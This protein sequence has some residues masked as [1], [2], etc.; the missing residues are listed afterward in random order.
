MGPAHNPKQM[1]LCFCCRA[2]HAAVRC[3]VLED[4]VSQIISDTTNQTA[5]LGITS[6]LWNNM[7]SKQFE[8]L[9]PRDVHWKP[10]NAL[11]FW[12]KGTNDFSILVYSCKLPHIQTLSDFL[13]SWCMRPKHAHLLKFW[14][15]SVLQNVHKLFSRLSGPSTLNQLPWTAGESRL[16][17]VKLQFGDRGPLHSHNRT[18]CQYQ[19]PLL[20]D[21]LKL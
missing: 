21:T 10:I 7:Y 20:L 11:V 13:S 16:C 6:R 4:V 3:T 17:Q 15:A 18:C 19:S 14:S 9:I 2:I 8:I 5:K 1:F 12:S